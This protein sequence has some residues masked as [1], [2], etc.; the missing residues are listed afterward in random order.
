[1]NSE[2]CWHDG[3]EYANN[4]NCLMGIFATRA[5]RPTRGTPVSYFSER[6]AR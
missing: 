6:W 4:K 2:D 5:E 1:M 3:P